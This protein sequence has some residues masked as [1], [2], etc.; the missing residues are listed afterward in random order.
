LV[1]A[2]VFDAFGHFCGSLFVVIRISRLYDGRYNAGVVSALVMNV[3]L[4][5]ASLSRTN[6]HCSGQPGK[7]AAMCIGEAAIQGVR[8]W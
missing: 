2:N 7:N 4:H 3:T 5:H 1:P 8:V 6:S